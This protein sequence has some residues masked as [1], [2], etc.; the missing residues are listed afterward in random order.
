M[1]KLDIKNMSVIEKMRLQRK[2]DI[3]KEAL[4]YCANH[5]HPSIV[6]DI[7]KDNLFIDAVDLKNNCTYHRHRNCYFTGDKV[8]QLG[9]LSREDMIRE[10]EK[11]QEK[12]A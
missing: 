10:Q 9:I 1:S 4:E 7:S 11:Y 5:A 6:Q 12:V 2:I 3:L 8:V